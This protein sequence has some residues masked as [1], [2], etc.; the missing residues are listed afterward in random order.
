[1]DE[2]AYAII[3]SNHIDSIEH[4]LHTILGAPSNREGYEDA[5]KVL[6]EIEAFVHLKVD[7]VLPK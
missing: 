4:A 5:I 3:A 6:K 2:I 7:E 1:M